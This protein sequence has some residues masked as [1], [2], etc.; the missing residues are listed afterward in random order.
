MSSS[1]RERSPSYWPWS[2]GTVTWL[3]SM[4]TRKS[5]GKKSSSVFGASPRATAVDRGRVVLDPVAVADLLH[6]LEVVLGAHAEALGLEQLALLL[7]LGQP[8]LELVPRCG[9]WPC[10]SAPRRRRSGWPGRRRSSSSVVTCLAGERVDHLD[11]LDLVAE[12]LD[13]HG[14]LVV[15]RVD[16]DGVAPHPELAPHEVHVVALVLHVDELAQDAALVDLL[17][18]PARGACC[19]GTPRASRGR[20][21]TTPTPPR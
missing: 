7:E 11:A 5:S 19:R 16:L 18:R 6:H 4:T 1:L 17:A 12:Q 3:S 21:C 2:C 15:G 13:A 20:R 14:V 10:A 9:R 8:L